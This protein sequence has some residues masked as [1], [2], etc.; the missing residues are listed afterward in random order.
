MA[1]LTKLDAS[2]Q[3]PYIGQHGNAW[4]ERYILDSDAAGKVSIVNGPAAPANGDVIRVGLLPA[5]MELFPHDAVMGVSDAFAGG[6]TFAVGFQYADGVDDA[7]V[8]QDD[9]Y[10]ITATSV[11]ALGITRGNNTG[12]RPVTLKKDAYLIV[13]NAGAAF[14]VQGF[15]DITIKG[16]NR[17]TI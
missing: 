11:A 17:G 16:R 2:Q 7:A 14:S 1:L 9:D 15:C 6:Q 3:T 5:G 12:V 8:P 13:T 4:L 10:F